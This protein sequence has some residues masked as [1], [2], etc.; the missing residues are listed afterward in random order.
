[1]SNLTVLCS[2]KGLCHGNQFLGGMVGVP[3]L[4]LH[5]VYCHVLTDCYADLRRLNGDDLFMLNR[6]MV[7]FHPLSQEFTN[8]DTDC[9][10]LEQISNYD[11]LR[12][13]FLN[14]PNKISL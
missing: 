3:T 2:L 9:Q 10:F 1:M 11:L 5:S 12:Q 13:R 7:R 8:H 14:T 4:H 6:N